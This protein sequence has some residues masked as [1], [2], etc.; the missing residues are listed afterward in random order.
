MKKIKFI[1][2]F[3]CLGY[4]ES[5]FGTLSACT[6]SIFIFLLFDFE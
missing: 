1:C 3:S 5:Y 4:F 6:V 2:V